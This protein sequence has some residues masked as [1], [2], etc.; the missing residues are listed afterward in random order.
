MRAEIFAAFTAICWGVGSLLE[1]KGVKLGGLSPVMGTTVRTAVSLLLLT[2]V[3]YPYWGQIRKAGAPSIALIAVGGGVIAGGLGIIFLYAALKSG[4]LSSVM[5]IAFCL[6]PIVGALL[7]YFVL[8]ERLS[9]I[10]LLGIA[11]CITGASLVTWFR[12]T[13]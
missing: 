1:K 12:G 10:Q 2:F 9:P 3:S 4:S 5:T 13:T 8:H 11:L 6:A 7:G